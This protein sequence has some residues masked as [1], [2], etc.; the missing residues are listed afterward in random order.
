MRIIE[1]FIHK[2]LYK[3]KSKYKMKPQGI[4]IHNTANDA[5]P[6]QE[7]EYM[8]SN[9][10]YLSSHYYVGYDD[11]IQKIPDNRNA[12][13]AGDGVKGFGNRKTI[14]IEICYS[15]S[16]GIRFTKA[17][18]NAAKL[19]AMKL[20]QYGWGIGKVYTHE[21]HSGKYCPHRTLDLGWKRFLSLVVE[22]L[23]E[24]PKLKEDEYFYIQLGAYKL[25]E[26]CMR[27]AQIFA[28]KLGFNLAIKFGSKD[29]LDW[30]TPVKPKK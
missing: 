8:E 21:V 23:E 2:D 19:T 6:L 4:T 11:V 30:V 25:E 14:C 29:V 24:K 5:T 3:K 18:R 9:D 10:K 1:D 15:K 22:Y 7:S 27:D 17:E 16:G 20:K 13:H 28:D 26:D 12:W